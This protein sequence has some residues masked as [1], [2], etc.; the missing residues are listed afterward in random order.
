MTAPA[1]EK[2][3]TILLQ[4]ATTVLFN[5][6]LPET[7]MEGT[8]VF[9]SGSQQSY[10][11]RT[12]VVH[13]G[14][15]RCGSKVLSI[16]TFGNEEGNKQHCDVVRIELKRRD[17]SDQELTLLSVP[18]VCGTVKAMARS[19]LK[20]RYPQLSELDLADQAKSCTDC[21]IPVILI[22]LDHYWSSVT[23]ENIQSIDGPVAARFELVLLLRR[24]VI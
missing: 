20:A 23:G 6:G 12:A 13:L 17:T 21:A 1:L 7:Q 4:T 22:R 5:P 11:S 9:D 24:I 18:S 10:I 2:N 3:T 14:L 8:V 16:V 19:D 15:K